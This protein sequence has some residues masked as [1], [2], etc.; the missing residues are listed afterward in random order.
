MANHR[1]NRRWVLLEVRMHTHYKARHALWAAKANIHLEYLTIRGSHLSEN[2]QWCL[3]E[4]SDF[5]SAPICVTGNLKSFSTA[6]N[7][8]KLAL[9]IVND[10]ISVLYVKFLP[11][12]SGH[13]LV[14]SRRLISNTGCQIL[15]GSA[16]HMFKRLDCPC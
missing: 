1:Q 16:A 12:A 11:S 2:R 3:F 13:R 5:P 7:D 9:H 4:T 6:P 14:T 8:I 10:L 15:S